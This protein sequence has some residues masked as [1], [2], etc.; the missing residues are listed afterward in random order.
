VR[1]VLVVFV[2]VVVVV[3]GGVLFESCGAWQAAAVALD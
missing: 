3:T 2:A 1:G